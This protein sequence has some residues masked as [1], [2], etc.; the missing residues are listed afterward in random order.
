M[1]IHSLKC[2]IVVFFSII[3]LLS[4]I[5]RSP[6]LI[7]KHI[8][9]EMSLYENVS[10]SPEIVVIEL[11]PRDGHPELLEAVLP[12]VPE[13]RVRDPQGDL[14]VG[15]EFPLKSLRDLME[16][17]HAFALDLDAFA[18]SVRVVVVDT[19]GAV[20]RIRDR[21]V[22]ILS[23]GARADVLSHGAMETRAR[24]QANQGVEQNRHRDPNSPSKR[25]IHC[26]DN[27]H[28]QFESRF[29]TCCCTSTWKCH[30][31]STKV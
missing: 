11:E 12:D 3:V 19:L 25:P 9:D 7:V 31:A 20:R 28:V 18:V 4:K 27:S 23:A 17:L 5:F 30:D 26:N 22:V 1:D 6:M 8:S 2:E 16:G 29:S 21:R 24:R 14:L 10:Y 15:G 13:L